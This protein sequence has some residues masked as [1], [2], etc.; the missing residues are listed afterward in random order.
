M[1]IYFLVEGRRT[2]PEVYTAWLSHLVPELTR[3][4]RYD[5]ASANSYFLISAEG[6]PSIIWEHM[7][8]AIEDVNRTG[9]YDYFVVSLDAD[10]ATV[11]DRIDE[12]KRLVLVENSPILLAF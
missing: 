4:K 10:E 2:E 9:G 12:I 8:N 6:Y 11:E 7:P 3:M 5:E 1:R